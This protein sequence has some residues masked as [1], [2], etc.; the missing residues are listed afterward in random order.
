MQE[1]HDRNLVEH[2]YQMGQYMMKRLEDLKEFGV[3][4]DIRGA[5]LMIGVEFVQNPETMEPFPTELGFGVRVGRHCILEQHMLIR[6]APHWVALAPPFIVTEAEIDDMV[7]R[8]GQALMAV[9]KQVR[10]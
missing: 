7:S 8:L 6:Y 5:G 4:G 1:L 2:C 10:G 3:V 9:L